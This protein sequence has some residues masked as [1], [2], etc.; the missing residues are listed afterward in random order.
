MRGTI[1]KLFLHEE[2]KIF[3]SDAHC[4]MEISETIYDHLT[5]E[6]REV[7]GTYQGQW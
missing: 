4:T 6:Y 7:C 5:G 3:P 1:K 2:Q